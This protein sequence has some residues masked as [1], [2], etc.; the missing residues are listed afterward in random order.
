[1]DNFT[2]YHIHPV[3]K[4]GS[5]II[6]FLHRFGFDVI[7]D[8]DV[9]LHRFVVTVASPLHDNLGRNTQGKGIADKSPAPTMGAN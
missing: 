2:E 1:M 3:S 7:S 4:R 8:I 5:K 9:R 6:E